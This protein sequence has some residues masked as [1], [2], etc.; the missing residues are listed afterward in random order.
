MSHPLSDI[1]TSFAGPNYGPCTGPGGAC[2]VNIVDFEDLAKG[3]SVELYNLN[4]HGVEYM[5]T[6]GGSAGKEAATQAENAGSWGGVIAAWL[7]FE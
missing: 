6:I 5:V 3:D 2:Q 1:L 4:T 7:G